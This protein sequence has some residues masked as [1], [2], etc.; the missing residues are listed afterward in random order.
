MMLSKARSSVREPGR[1]PAGFGGLPLAV[2]F[3]SLSDTAPSLPALLGAS[4]EAVPS[5]ATSATRYERSERIG[6]ALHVMP[7]LEF[8]DVERHVSRA[9]FVKRA[10]DPALEQRPE[11]LNRVRVD[12]ADNILLMRVLDD[13]VRVLF[14]EAAIANP[15]VCDQQIHLVGND[16]AHESL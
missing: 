3:R 15:L 12:R 6:F 8:V 5:G 14:V 9:H 10:D 11:A 1:V 16:L 13:A 4:A 7:E 2:G